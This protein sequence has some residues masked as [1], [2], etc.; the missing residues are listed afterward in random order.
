MK[1]LYPFLLLLNLSFFFTVFAQNRKPF[2]EKEASWVSINQ[3]SFDDT[4]L[5]LEA[6][7]GYVY[8]VSER[9][10]SLKHRAVYYR[11]AIKVLTE[12]G[13]QNSSDVSVNFNPSYQ[14]LV[15]HSI[16]IIRGK[17]VINQL[18]LSKI[19][20]IQQEKELDRFMYDGSLSSILF[21]EDVR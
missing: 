9:Q 16:Q 4:H 10:T 2:A 6:E 8:L 18:N 13:I 21:L 12:A 5:D 3:Y 19:K 20:T 7:D 11:T 1:P 15:F 14:Q 17:Q